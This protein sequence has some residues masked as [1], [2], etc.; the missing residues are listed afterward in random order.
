LYKTNRDHAKVGSKDV[1]HHRPIFEEDKKCT[2]FTVK[3]TVSSVP[4]RGL[5]LTWKL[6]EYSLNTLIVS[7]TMKTLKTISGAL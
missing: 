7:G 5:C 1:R 3:N 4:L 2:M 6:V